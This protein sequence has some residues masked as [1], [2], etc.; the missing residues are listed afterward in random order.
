LTRNRLTIFRAMGLI[1]VTGG[2]LS[3]FADPDD[4]SFVALSLIASL[5]LVL[6][7]HFAIE[8]NRRDAFQAGHCR[9]HAR[10][11]KGSLGSD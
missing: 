4:R 2:V 6:P 11:E 7:V 9:E 5:V 10:D 8:G 1:A 3:L